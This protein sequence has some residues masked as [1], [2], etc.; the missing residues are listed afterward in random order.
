MNGDILA[1]L[2]FREP[3]TVHRRGGAVLTVAVHAKQ[4]D[5]D[6]GVIESRD[7]MITGYNEKPSLHCD[8]SVGIYAYERR[9]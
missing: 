4:I 7:G 8:I 2:D 6:L 5:I 9:R 3:L 1:A